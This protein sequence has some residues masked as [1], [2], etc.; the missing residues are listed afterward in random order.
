MLAVPAELKALG[1]R[2]ISVV[3]GKGKAVSNAGSV[4]KAALYVPWITG[5]VAIGKIPG[6]RRRTTT[7]PPASSRDHRNVWSLA[8]RAQTQHEQGDGAPTHGI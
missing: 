7:L 2:G 3:I 6:K 8:T 4:A 1:A 5:S